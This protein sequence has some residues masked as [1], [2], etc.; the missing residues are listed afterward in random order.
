MENLSRYSE[1][2]KDKKG[3]T[4]EEAHQLAML[5]MIKRKIEIKYGIKNMNEFAKLVGYNRHYLAGMFTGTTK[6][7]KRLIATICFLGG[8]GVD[9]F[10]EQ[11]DITTNDEYINTKGHLIVDGIDYGKITK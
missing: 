10:Y 8:I 9:D 3:L 1:T 7:P 2:L 4:I 5:R 11:Y 6:I